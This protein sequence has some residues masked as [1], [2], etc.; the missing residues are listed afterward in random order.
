MKLKLKDVIDF[1]S[2]DGENH[3]ILVINESAGRKRR[4]ALSY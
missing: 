4:K 3:L 1:N 2:F